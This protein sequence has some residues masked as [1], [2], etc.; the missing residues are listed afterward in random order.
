MSHRFSIL[1]LI[2]ALVFTLAWIVLG[3]ISPGYELFG[4]TIE[5]YSWISQPVSGLGLGVTA[6]WMNTA[7]VL[8]G[9]LVTTGVLSTVSA[10]RPRGRA[11]RTA[12][13]FMSFMGL[14]MI[15]CGVFTLESMMLHLTGFLLA[16]PLPTIGLFLAALS[17]R[18]DSPRL[19]L[20]AC[21]SG[22]VALVLFVVFMAV[23]EPID[24]GGNHGIAGLL[25]RAL[26]VVAMAGVVTMTLMIPKVRQPVS[27]SDDDF[28]LAESSSL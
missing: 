25:Q 8:S 10:W 24:A 15:M 28:D 19:A 7:F 1:A 2:G 4:D 9:I 3:V 22:L 16:V 27:Q 18:R 21:A 5:P 26:I 13:V 11:G 17:L 6:A 14:G 20:S 23:F 12:V